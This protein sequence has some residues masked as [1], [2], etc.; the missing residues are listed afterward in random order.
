MSPHPNAVEVQT[1]HTRI[2][3]WATQS[4]IPEIQIVVRRRS[5][6]CLL[7]PLLNL[8]KLMLQIGH[9][10]PL[11]VIQRLRRHRLASEIHS[12]E[13]TRRVHGTASMLS[14]RQARAFAGRIGF[15]HG[16]CA[17]AAL[18]HRRR[19]HPPLAATAATSWLLLAIA[20]Q[21]HFLP[22]FPPMAKGAT[23]FAISNATFI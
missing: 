3:A 1:A 11:S 6:D 18:P 9:P 2:C 21:T 10:H 16:D 20:R 14:C 13:C 23:T 4:L 22:S 19:T 5:R 12:H 7:L 17:D 8:S 15:R